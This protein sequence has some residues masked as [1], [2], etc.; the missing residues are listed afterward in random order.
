VQARAEAYVI[1]AAV[2][3]ALL[4]FRDGALE[5]GLGRREL[6]GFIKSAANRFPVRDRNFDVL[7]APALETRRKSHQLRTGVGAVWMLCH[8]PRDLHHPR[9]QHLGNLID[10]RGQLLR[11]RRI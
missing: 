8:L 4:R 2:D 9:G 1:G 3:V 11:R 5:P 6:A 10:G 7:T